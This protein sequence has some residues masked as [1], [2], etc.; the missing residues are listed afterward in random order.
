M[1]IWLGVL[2]GLGLVLA[3]GPSA[4]RAD[5]WPEIQGKGRHSVWNE[6][7]ILEKFPEGGAPV[8]WRTPIGA[9]YTGPAVAEGRVFTADYRRTPAGQV[10]RA[11]CLDEQS[12]HVLWTY[13]NPEVRYGD[14]PYG[15]GPRATPTVDGDRVYVLGAVGDL[16]CLAVKD[17]ELLWKVNFKKDFKARQATWGFASAPLAWGDLV[18]CLAGS[19]PDGKVIALDRRTGHEVWRGLPNKGSTAYAA[20]IVLQAGGVDQLIQW[21]EGAV[22]SLDPN[23]GRVFWEQP[24]KGDLL[25]STP[26]TDGNLLFVSAFFNGPMMLELAPDKPAAGLLWRGKS[27]SEIDTDGLHCMTSTPVILDAHVYGV[28]SYGQLRCLD[29]RTGQR[30]WETQEVTR[31]KARWASAFLTRNGRR[32]FINNDRGELIIA[33]FSP[34]GYH[35]ISRMNLIKPTTPGGG[36]R[37]LGAVNWVLPAYANRHILIRNDEEI[38]RVSLEA[39]ATKPTTSRSPSE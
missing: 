13:E 20:P 38:I 22:S 17:G 29:A 2:L 32:F 7:G 8:R 25:V 12:G 15:T 16:Y 19:A 39:P 10:E 36:K 27:Q 26:V 6:G 33:E 37:E 18:I 23:T 30:L 34:Q 11:L 28:C 4:L 9:G 24:F 35:E 1:G 3:L 21:H 14:L 31:E 5:D